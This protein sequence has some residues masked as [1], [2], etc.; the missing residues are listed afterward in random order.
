MFDCVMGFNEILVTMFLHFTIYAYI[1]V[2]FETT[3]FYNSKVTIFLKL[4]CLSLTT[5]NKQ[6]SMQQQLSLFMCLV[7]QQY[8][9]F[10]C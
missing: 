10:T 4:I 1:S 3:V 2:K 8:Y 9:K 5:N 7:L 6:L